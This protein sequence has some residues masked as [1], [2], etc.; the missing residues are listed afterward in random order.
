M[1]VGSKSHQY[2]R[3]LLKMDKA[4]EGRTKE[5]RAEERRRKFR[6]ELAD[7]RERALADLEARGYSVRGKTTGQIRRALLARSKTKTSHR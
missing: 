4:A 1:P 6:A 2:K 5:S 3:I 7:L